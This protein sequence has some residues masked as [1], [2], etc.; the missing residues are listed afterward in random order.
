MFS[1]AGAV[2]FALL[3]GYGALCDLRAL[4]IPNWISLV[5]AIGFF[6]FAMGSGMDW[7]GVLAHYATGVGA[8]AALAVLFVFGLLGGGDVKLFA[9]AAVWMGWSLLLPFTLAVALAGGILSLLILLARAGSRRA[10]GAPEWIAPR[11]APGSA[12]PY[13][14]AIAAG[15]V[16]VMIRA[17]F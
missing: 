13:G 15:G 12:A 14:I 8:L 11:L 4:R 17:V 7:G 16:Y 6:P 5:L 9:A 10:G 3:L 1:P 2:F